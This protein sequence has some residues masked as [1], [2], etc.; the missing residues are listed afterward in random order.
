MCNQSE[1]TGAPA[2]LA[3]PIT[4]V[5]R[6]GVETHV[7]AFGQGDKA[8]RFECT[9]D[10]GGLITTFS[11]GEDNILAG[12]SVGPMHGSTFWTSPQSDWEWPPPPAIGEDPYAVSID[13]RTPA[14]VLTSGE[15][16]RLGVRVVKRFSPDLAGQAVVLDYE[17]ANIGHA[18]RSFAP[19]EISRV[20]PGGITFFPTGD[21]EVIAGPKEALPI[22]ESGAV[23]WF[24]HTPANV[25]G[26]H[27]LFADG[28]RGWI[29]HVA[30]T[31]V[32]VKAF[33]DIPLG[34]AAPGEAEIEI[35]ATPK[36]VE[37]EQQGAY[38]AIAPGERLAWRVRWYLRRLPAAIEAKAR[39]PRLVEIVD[40][41][42]ETR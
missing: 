3:S 26:E 33:A 15:E 42:L 13:E 39:N 8:T 2:G 28:R 7:L 14:I 9:A 5:S 41:L 25:T 38:Q 27:K 34:S 4:R 10:R 18:T 24:E 1:D 23:T 11:L 6:A 22:T 40:D 12:E 29:A 36:Y 17:I 16:P 37:V 31:L 20:Y 19:W 35:Y 21:G 32:F 30:G